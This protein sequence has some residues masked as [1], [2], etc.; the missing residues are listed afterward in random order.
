MTASSGRGHEIRAA[1]ME[2]GL[3]GVDQAFGLM[4][5]GTAAL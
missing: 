5:G 2:D 1:R 3:L 4:F